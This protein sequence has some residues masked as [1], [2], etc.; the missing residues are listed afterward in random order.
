MG[1]LEAERTTLKRRA[2]AAEEELHKLQASVK[3]LPVTSSGLGSSNFCSVKKKRY[4]FA[5]C[6]FL[7][8]RW[9]L[10]GVRALGWS[11]GH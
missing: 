2:T 3:K 10:Y 1:Q 5:A 9:G 7:L 11:A 8:T 4:Y 6:N